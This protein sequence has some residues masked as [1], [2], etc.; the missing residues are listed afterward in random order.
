M[1]ELFNSKRNVRNL[2]L[3][4]ILILLIGSTV[5]EQG[6]A[7]TNVV[8]MDDFN[9]GDYDEWIIEGGL[10]SIVNNSLI[11]QGSLLWPKVATIFRESQGAFGNWSFDIKGWTPS[12]WFIA[13]SPDHRNVSGYRFARVVTEDNAQFFGLY[14]VLN[15]QETRIA[16][17]TA[18][19]DTNWH[20]VEIERGLDGI[21]S[22]DLNGSQIISIV[23]VNISTSNYFVFGG[24]SPGPGIDN[25]DV[26]SFVIS[27]PAD[28][29][30]LEP[31]EYIP[32]V[33]VFA[34]V[35]LLTGVILFVEIRR[36]RR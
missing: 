7:Q 30:S 4:S 16:Y 25:V 23:D 29:T 14:R 27:T 17:S 3:A 15:G 22:I 12:V 5:Y 31:D 18:T 34:A 10:F 24:Y 33:Y 35:I 1:F 13:S 19:N 8:W 28:T 6:F 9:D 32:F 20:H 11:L 2:L 36:R 26:D 21:F